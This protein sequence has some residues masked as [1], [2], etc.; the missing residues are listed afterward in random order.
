MEVQ[1][2]DYEN[3]AF[4]VFII[5]LT[6][7]ILAFDLHLYMPL[8]KVDENMKRAHVRDAVKGQKFWFRKY[9]APDSD[10][11]EGEGKGEKQDHRRHCYCEADAEFEEMTI[12]EIMTGKGNDYP[13]LIC[14]CHAYLDYIRC[15]KDTKKKVGG[16]LDFIRA[17]AVG[18]VLTAASWIRQFVTNHPGYGKDSVVSEEIAYDLLMECRDIGEGRKQC[19]DLLGSVK[20]DPIV[21]DEAYDVPLSGAKLAG[22]MRADV[23]RKLMCRQPFGTP[24]DRGRSFDLETFEASK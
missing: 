8:V 23:I 24:K 3:A 18:E 12:A 10:E 7:I 6:R 14:L 1:L 4:T 22:G 16:Y 21:V 9:M 11:E 19:P 5:L 20:I 2:T 17:R 13:G 15:D